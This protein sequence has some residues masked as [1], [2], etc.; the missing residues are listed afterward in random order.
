LTPVTKADGSMDREFS[1]G[2]F[3][4]NT[5]REYGT[6]IILFGPVGKF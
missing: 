3:I 5:L 6:N 4:T 2:T 1:A